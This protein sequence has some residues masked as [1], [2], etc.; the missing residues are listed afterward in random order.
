MMLQSRKGTTQARGRLR[1]RKLLDA[2]RRLL[3]QSTLD[4]IGLADVAEAAGVPKTSAYHF[5]PSIYDL[6]VELSLEL[7]ADLRGELEKPLRHE[8][9]EWQ[10]VISELVDR[11]A[12]FFIENSAA[13]QLQI[14]PKTPPDIK[15][16]DRVN[17]F[18]LARLFVG[19]IASLFRL[20][21]TMDWDPI[22]FRAIEVADL[23]FVLSVR[24]SGTVTPF[25]SIEA[26]RAM[27]AYLELYIPKVLSPA[28]RS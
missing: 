15:S 2:A 3:G 25:F 19:H 22:F 10:G 1:R 20:P 12:A 26:S 21:D 5:F 18:A 4:V 14:G 13:R 28:V 27:V 16:R 23:M 24:E 7:A 11:G 6:Y 8:H 9:S 17:D